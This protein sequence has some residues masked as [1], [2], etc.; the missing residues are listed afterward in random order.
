MTRTRTTN[1]REGDVMAKVK[2]TVEFEYDIELENYDYDTLEEAI[3]ADRQDMENDSDG[4]AF[5]LEGGEY[6]VSS[7]ECN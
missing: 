4:I 1:P 5:M 2:V 3:E 7:K 6:K